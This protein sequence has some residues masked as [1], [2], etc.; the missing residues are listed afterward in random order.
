M[1]CRALCLPDTTTYWLHG[2]A[3]RH[4]FEP[5][6]S[7]DI[8]HT[9]LTKHAEGLVLVVDQS[10]KVLERSMPAFEVHVAVTNSL[11]FDILT[12]SGALATTRPFHGG[13]WE[14]GDFDPDIAS[15]LLDF[16]VSNTQCSDPTDLR[17]VFNGLRQGNSTLQMHHHRIH[18]NTKS[19]ISCFTRIPLDQFSENLLPMG[20]TCRSTKLLR[21]VLGFF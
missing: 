11:R 10:A 7:L 3:L 15:K 12:P 21:L 8:L 13:S 4:S 16:D 19:L 6:G 17:R 20:D 9:V 18:P 14:V 1:A 2:L 5:H